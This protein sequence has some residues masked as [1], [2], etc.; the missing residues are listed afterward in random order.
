[1]GGGGGGAAPAAPLA[2]EEESRWLLLALADARRAVLQRWDDGDLNDE[3]AARLEAELDLS[4][5]SLRGTAG[6][7]VGG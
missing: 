2:G 5:V 4:E 3:S 6:E 1:V 7:I